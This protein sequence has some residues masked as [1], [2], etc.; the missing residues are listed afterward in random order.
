MP[1]NGANTKIMKKVDFFMVDPFPDYSAGACL[2]LLDPSGCL[3]Q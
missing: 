3:E 2:P 1:N